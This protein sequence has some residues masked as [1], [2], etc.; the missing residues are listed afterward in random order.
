MKLTTCIEN[1]ENGNLSDAKAQAKH[2][3]KASLYRTMRRT[4]GW[5]HEK[6]FASATYLKAPS[7]ATYDTACAV[8]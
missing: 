3:T 4:F 2:L 6:A 7:Q 1:F 5:S 8:A